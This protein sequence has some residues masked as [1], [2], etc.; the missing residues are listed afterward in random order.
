MFKEIYLNKNSVLHHVCMSVFIFSS[1]ISFIN[2]L[3]EKNT[4]E[5]NS[6][7][8]SSVLCNIIMTF[9]CLKMK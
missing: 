3:M 7:V 4:N 1:F 9:P 6:Y 8:M 2:H 5:P